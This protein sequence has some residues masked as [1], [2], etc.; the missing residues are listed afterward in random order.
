M[1]ICIYVYT[2]NSIYV[3]IYV[4]TNISTS[5]FGLFAVLSVD[6]GVPASGVELATLRMWV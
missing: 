4:Y 1:Y 6:V 3:Y 5:A 2:C